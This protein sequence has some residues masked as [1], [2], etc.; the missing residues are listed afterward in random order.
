LTGIEGMLYELSD[1]DLTKTIKLRKLPVKEIY[2]Y[3][4]LKRIN[5]LNMLLEK[6]ARLEELKNG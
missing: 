2:I 5:I 3:A 6:T 4:Y 1:G